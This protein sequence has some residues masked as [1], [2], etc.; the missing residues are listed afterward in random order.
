MPEI[1]LKEYFSKL[2]NLLS[3]RAVDEVLLHCRQILQFY[4]KNVTAYRFLG[5]GLVMSGRWEEGRESLRRVLSVIPDDYQAHLALSEA[6]ERLGRSDEAIW[7]LER[8]FEQRPNDKDIIDALRA[9]YSLHRN[10]NNL[11]IQLTSAAVAR[12]YARSGAYNQAVDTLRS[13]LSRMNERLDLKLL[14]AQ[15][16]QEHGEQE[17]AAELALEVL[18]VLPD[19]LEANKIMAELWLNVN[20]PSD[21]QRYVNRLE[22][23]DPY[24]AVE[25]AQGYPPEDDAFKLDE[26]DY[27]RTAQ[28]ELASS[29]L[30]WLQ[31][32]ASLPTPAGEV[33]QETPSEDLSDWA[34]AMLSGR[35][36][37]APEP[38]AETV[39]E[40]TSVRF[41][42]MAEEEQ[43]EDIDF[44]DMFGQPEPAD[45]DEL[46]AMFAAPSTLDPDDPMAWLHGAGVEIV[47][48]GIDDARYEDLFDD[49]MPTIEEEDPMAWLRDST[50]GQGTDD[51]NDEA[52]FVGAPADD[53][54][55]DPMAWLRDSR[56][57]PGAEHVTPVSAAPA[58]DD[59][60]PFAWRG[61]DSG[62]T[63]DDVLSDAPEVDAELEPF[64]W[65]RDEQLLDEALSLDGLAADDSADVWEGFAAAETTE[66]DEPSSEDVQPVVPGARKGLT[67]MLQEANLDWISKPAEEPVVDD[68]M[69]E[70][71]NQFGLATEPKPPVTENPDWLLELDQPESSREALTGE[72]SFGDEFTLDAG[73]PVAQLAVEAAEEETGMSDEYLHKPVEPE[74]EDVDWMR[75]LVS[76]PDDALEAADTEEALKA[77]MP[78]WMAA[79]EPEAE[80]GETDDAEIVAEGD[81]SWLGAAETGDDTE[82][83][84]VEAEIP[85]WL[86]NLEPNAQSVSAADDST[87][88]SEPELEPPDMSDFP[89][90]AD[91]PEEMTEESE[92]AESEAVA[93]EMPDW[94]SEMAPEEEESEPD[95]EP[96]AEE[97]L[98]WLSAA[99]ETQPD[100]VQPDEAEALTEGDIPDW[101]AALEPEEVES[102]ET[103][104][105]AEMSEPEPEMDVEPEAEPEPE[106]EPPDASDFPWM[107]DEEEAVEQPA[108]EYG[109]FPWMSDEAESGEAE[110]S[111]PAAITAEMPDWLASAGLGDEDVEEIE[112]VMP[113]S[114]EPLPE[115]EE[116]VAEAIPGWLSELEPEADT[117]PQIAEDDLSWLDDE[118]AGEE[119]VAAEQPLLEEDEIEEERIAEVGD[120]YDEEDYEPEQEEEYG[121]LSEADDAFLEATPAHN[122]PDWLNAMVPGLDVDYEPGS[123]EYADEDEEEPVDDDTAQREFAWLNNLV[124]EEIAATRRPEFAFS[125]L[126]SWLGSSSVSPD[127][128][129][130]DDDLPDW[131]SDDADAD[132]PEWLR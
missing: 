17:E 129:S 46:E 88:S 57:E 67:A 60:D 128:S 33:V 22:A 62:V 85:D 13:A 45:A 99:E 119:A 19:C 15:T 97:D 104:P 72:A 81:L 38:E 78:D 131:P 75:S 100:E 109:D 71:M 112:A 12:Q 20:R 28:S 76:Q 31:E 90:M 73:E 37:A 116:P 83:E 58:D 53:D 65:L 114:V 55:G 124:E 77:E 47:D 21:A 79:L 52:A 105:E 49:S 23:V 3:E 40:P 132:V 74:D 56:L 63:L 11:K 10:I 5:R 111:E 2:N 120:D 68:E 32:I 102:T 92:E 86:A 70:W 61:N 51:T 127:D 24:L 103:M 16:L 121:F 84:L 87:E 89:W 44:N 34:S 26:L 7:H 8:A 110:V 4:P 39:N 50:A 106:L 30:D 101:M 123:E 42:A 69:D 27:V 107:V 59:D 6:N 54:D 93:A 108:A 126:P 18:G 25:V 122:A 14:L 95:A 9:L 98:S 80:S 36:A 94:L 29:R 91:E 41:A 115:P 48:G 125:R 35:N 64:D 117:E 43:Q 130:A 96:A 1:S 118:E 66:E 82:A 113:F